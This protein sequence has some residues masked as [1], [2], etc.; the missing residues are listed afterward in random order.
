MTDQ[1]KT[2]ERFIKIRAAAIVHDAK[3]ATSYRN[4][5]EDL[6]RALVEAEKPTTEALRAE[7]EELR[8]QDFGV[9]ECDA[10]G[11][12]WAN[13]ELDAVN[14][15]GQRVDPDGPAPSGQCPECGALCYHKDD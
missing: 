12:I 8:E 10:C 1:D 3:N 7:I 15:Y 13:D 9:S 2:R 11:E 14:D 6:V 4:E 5:I